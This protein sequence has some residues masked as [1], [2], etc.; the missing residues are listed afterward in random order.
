MRT[1]SRLSI[2]AFTIAASWI[3]NQAATA[4]TIDDIS[5]LFFVGTG[6]QGFDPDDVAALGRTPGFAAD[7]N[8]MFLAAGGPSTG[9]PV[10]V[11]SQVVTT[12]HQLP[13]MATPDDPAIVDSTWTIVNDAS[14]SILQP[15]LLFTTLDPLDTYPGDPQI[16]LDADL[17]ALLTFQPP[18]GPG[19]VYGGVVLPDLAPGASTQIL[20]RYVVAGPLEISDVSQ[21]LAPLGLAA[22]LSY[23]AVPEPTTLLLCCIGLAG[24][25]LAGRRDPSV[26]GGRSPQSE[27]S[28]ESVGCPV[29]RAQDPA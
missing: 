4:L 8:D 1:G 7:S 5:P 17:L 22:A 26:R 27:E 6:G 25:A 23:T 2:L 21:V 9:A 3:G 12:V 16:G 11:S 28:Q 14:F 13:A 10:Q 24:I 15:I 18:V 29:P 19:I 20:V